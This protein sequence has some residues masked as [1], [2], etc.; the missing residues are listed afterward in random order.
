MRALAIGIAVCVLVWIASGGH[1]FFLPLLFIPLGL[2]TFGQ[3]RS[4]DR[5]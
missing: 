2:F 3:K 1:V 4:R 5:Y